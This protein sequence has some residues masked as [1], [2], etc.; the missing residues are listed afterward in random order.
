MECINALPGRVRFKSL[1]ILNRKD[2]SDYIEKYIESL[3]G[4]KSSR[5]TQLTGSILVYYDEGKTNFNIIKENVEKALSVAV[6]NAEHQFDRFQEYFH[7]LK[8]KKKSKKKF[9]LWSL[10]YL[11]LK[12]KGATYGKFAISRNYN[13]LKVASAVTI[14]GGYPLIKKFYKKFAKN[15]PTDADILLKLTA[16][17][18]TIMRE[19]SKGV[20][21]L[22]LKELND[23]IKFS[24]EVESRKALIDSYGDN[25][26]LALK[27]S[28]EGV[29][30]LVSLDKL[31]IGDYIYANKGEVIPVDGIIEEGS[32][33]I[34]HLYCTGQS[35]ISNITK[36][37]KIYE[38][39][40]ILSG[41]LKIKVTSLPDITEKKD[42]SPKDLYIH[43]KIKGFQD[44]MT[45]IAIITAG[46]SNIFTGN[47]FNALSVL[48]ALSPKA[49]EVA[50]DSGIKNY[51]SLLH[52]HNIYLKNPNTFEK[53]LN[54]NNVIFDKTGTLTYGNM[55]I[56]SITSFDKIYSEKDILKICAAC[57]VGNYHPISVTLQAACD[58]ID[59]KKINSSALI[60]SQGIKANYDNREVLI[61]NK[62]L[63]EDNNID[64]VKAIEKYNNSQRELTTPIFVAINKTLAGIIILDDI[65]RN[66]SKKLID[67]L[68]HQGINNISILTGDAHPKAVKI[69]SHLGI[70]KIYSNKNYLEK[71]EIIKAESKN[72][73]VMMIGD[74]INDVSAMKAS[75]I[76]VSFTNSSCDK[77]KLHS[78]CIIN[79][80]RLT[81]ISDLISISQ[82][83]YTAITHTIVLSNLYNITLGFIAFIGRLNLFLSKSLN[84]LNSLLV[85]L[86]N[87]RILYLKPTKIDENFYLKQK[88]NYVG[89]LN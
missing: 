71:A 34:N 9:L 88:R 4:V 84:T 85:L 61:G 65:I 42:I 74:G 31:K 18:F 70:N 24:A 36:G 52:K 49:T 72:S 38:G 40:A 78:D 1:D 82:K 6:I 32:A 41:N 68:K 20:L 33:V 48:L 44:K 14:I 45:P 28:P 11:Y 87:Q 64:F 22:I 67:K 73:I 57:E 69:A 43:N 19:S 15:V 29:N 27:E 39:T 10:F 47:I 25:F 60:P 12:I 8:N 89:L 37:L 13:V 7:A 23:Y 54:I 86:L 16:L 81:K 30:I 50:L 53:I 51:M 46:L 58:D 59:I 56:I 80:D 79:D 55:K 66:D 75:H 2:I 63:M 26:K 83:S 77:I 3:Y 21:V 76:S 17:S 62:K 35:V 5:V